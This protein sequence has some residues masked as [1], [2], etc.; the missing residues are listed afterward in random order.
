MTNINDNKTE[1][2]KGLITKYSKR[3]Y[4]LSKKIARNTRLIIK[5]E[6]NLIKHKIK[7]ENGKTKIINIDIHYERNNASN[8]YKL[9]ADK[10][11]ADN[12]G[13]YDGFKIEEFVDDCKNKNYNYVIAKVYRVDP[14]NDAEVDMNIYYCKLEDFEKKLNNWT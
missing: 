14:H 2:L 3:N 12:Y 7:Q 9:Y 6:I 5:H 4:N 10:L 11:Y 8:L 1:R 13:Y